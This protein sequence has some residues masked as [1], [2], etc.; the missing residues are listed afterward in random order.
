M[1]N[2]YPESQFPLKRK[3]TLGNRTGLKMSKKKKFSS[4]SRCFFLFSCFLFC[5]IHVCF[6]VLIVLAVAFCPHCT[7]HKHKHKHKHKHPCPRQDFF[8]VFSCTLCLIRTCVFVSA[9][10][11]FAFL[12]LL[13][14]QHKHLYLSGIR[15]R[16]PSQRSA[17]DPRLKLPSQWDRQSMPTPA[18]EPIYFTSEEHWYHA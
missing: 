8:F 18:F 5:F 13:T 11:H 10:Q 16:N 1:W 6:L 17:A 7:T 15:T 3:R 12:S 2:L 9:F 4:N 14:T